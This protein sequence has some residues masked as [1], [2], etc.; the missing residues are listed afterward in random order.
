M[1]D[2]DQDQDLR[3]N[4]IASLRNQLQLQGQREVEITKKYVDLLLECI[5][6]VPPNDQQAPILPAIRRE[7]Q[8]V[9]TQVATRRAEL[10]LLNQQFEAR[11]AQYEQLQNRFRELSMTVNAFSAGSVFQHSTYIF[12][13]QPTGAVP[14][15]AILQD[16]PHNLAIR[17]A[18]AAP[19]YETTEASDEL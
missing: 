6:S 11:N 19:Q 4:I 5:N 7:Y 12:Q 1:A 16:S 15:E 18:P 3:D 14:L 2:Q 13:G 17:P 9:E 8:I 10:Q